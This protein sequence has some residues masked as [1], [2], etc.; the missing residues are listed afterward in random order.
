MLEEVKLEH[1][2]EVIPRTKSKHN[3]VFVVICLGGFFSV[4][5]LNKEGKN[6]VRTFLPQSKSKLHQQ[7]RPI[8]N[9]ICALKQNES[10][11]RKLWKT[12]K[13]WKSWHEDYSLKRNYPNSKYLHGKATATPFEVSLIKY[14]RKFFH[15]RKNH[16]EG[17]FQPCHQGREILVSDIGGLSQWK[18]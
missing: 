8:V 16:H 6:W 10:E 1:K 9:G 14:T 3:Q 12:I 15:I 2:H 7:S 17:L 13:Y 11:Y 4:P 5:G 18:S